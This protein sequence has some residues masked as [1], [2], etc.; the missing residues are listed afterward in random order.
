MHRQDTRIVF[1]VFN[2]TIG[3]VDSV[4]L[5]A[6]S[7]QFCID[8]RSDEEKESEE[9]VILI[10]ELFYSVGDVEFLR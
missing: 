6:A 8:S 1:V 2:Q 7:A 10:R 4:H 3:T 5:T 9:M